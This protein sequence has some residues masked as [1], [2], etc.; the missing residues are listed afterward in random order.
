MNCRNMIYSGNLTL[1]GVKQLETTL[2]TLKVP[3]GRC[4]AGKQ[5]PSSILFIGKKELLTSCFQFVAES[6]MSA[7]T[8]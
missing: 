6:A 4:W 8:S 5:I 7:D 3:S 1:L 2:L